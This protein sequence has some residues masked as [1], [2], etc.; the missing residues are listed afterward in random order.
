MDILLIAIIVIVVGGVGHVAGALLGALLIGV[1]DAF[2]KAY[3]PDF[4]LFTVY[5]A[6]IVILLSKPSGLLGRRVNS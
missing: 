5:L 1:V 2:G 4:A 3:F 6:M